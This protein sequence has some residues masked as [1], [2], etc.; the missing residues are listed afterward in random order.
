MVPGSGALVNPAMLG[1][2]ALLGP[3]S[4]SRPTGARQGPVR[5]RRDDELTRGD[6][7]ARLLQVQG[8]AG[9]PAARVPENGRR[10]A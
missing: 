1:D 5:S 10:I 8:P 7:S 9:I 6:G 3:R 2:E 4:P